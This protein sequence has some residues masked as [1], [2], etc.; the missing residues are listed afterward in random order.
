M[1]AMLL[2]FAKLATIEIIAETVAPAILAMP[3]KIAP[4]LQRAA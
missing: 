2:I 3:L 4:A 1:I